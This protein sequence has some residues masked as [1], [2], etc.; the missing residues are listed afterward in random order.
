MRWAQPLSE[1]CPFYVLCEAEGFAPD[2]DDARF[3][4]VI[5]QALDAGDVK[6]AV[7]AQS[8][9]QRD[10]LWRI[11]E[12]FEAEQELFRVMID[13][14]ISLPLSAM[15]AFSREVDE[16]LNTHI[17]EFLGLHILG[18]LGDGNLHVTTGLPTPER[19]DDLKALVYGLIAK[20]GGSI[21]A[22]HG[23]GLNKRDYLGYS[24]S[25]EEIATMRLLKKA[26]DPKNTLNPGKILQ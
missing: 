2:M 8:A 9:R 1:S 22:E 10:E 25:P 3:E 26:L 17:P 19:S 13:F 23:I 15:D 18:H 7:I 20:H 21:S 4:A 5:M 12:D 6:D 14:D 24:R 16:A 11:R